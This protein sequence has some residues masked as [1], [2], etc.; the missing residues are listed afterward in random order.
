LRILFSSHFFVLANV[1]SVPK[2]IDI[3][4][5]A[6]ERHKFFDETHN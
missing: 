6:N 4:K 1:L 2:A 3:N 5:V